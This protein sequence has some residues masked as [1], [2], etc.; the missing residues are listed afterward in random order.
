[1]ECKK[2]HLIKVSKRKIINRAKILL[3]KIDLSS[4]EIK[5]N[6]IGVYYILDVD[7]YSRQDVDC[8]QSN[9]IQ[10]G[11]KVVFSNKDI[12]T[13]IYA[14][15]DYPD[16]SACDYK[17]RIQAEK[18]KYDKGNN[19]LLQQVHE[20]IIWWNSGSWIINLKSN[21]GK[22]KKYHEKNGHNHIHEMNPYSEVVKLIDELLP[23][24]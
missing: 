13:F 4:S 14:H 3:K 22:L 11:I 2:E 15:I 18:Y 24:L 23:D 12:E 1:L 7:R 16:S 17:T 8:V 20:N 5:K 6:R 9:M 21:M 19:L 10:C